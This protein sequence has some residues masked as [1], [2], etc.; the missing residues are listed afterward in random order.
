MIVSRRLGIDSKS[1]FYG[2]FVWARR[3]LNRRKRRFPARADAD[4]SVDFISDTADAGTESRGRCLPFSR[5][6]PHSIRGHPHTVECEPF[7][8]PVAQS[9]L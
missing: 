1:G 5:P 4:V 8:P 6:S 7:A 3:A 2:G 9:S